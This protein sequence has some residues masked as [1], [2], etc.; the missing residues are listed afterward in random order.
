MLEACREQPV[1]VVA[2]QDCPGDAADVGGHALRYGLGQ[3]VLEGNV[4]DGHAAAGFEDAGNL[5]EYG[6]FVG[7]KIENAV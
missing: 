3:L 2:D 4:A 7:S 1:S 6:R 5:A